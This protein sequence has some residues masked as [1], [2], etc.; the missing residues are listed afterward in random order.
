MIFFHYYQYHHHY[1]YINSHDH[2]C[3]FYLNRTVT[4]DLFQEICSA[5]G[6]CSFETR[7]TFTLMFNGALSS[8]VINV[9]VIF[10]MIFYFYTE[11]IGY[12]IPV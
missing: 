12:K 5:R 6:K 11:Q 10:D 8:F 1:N 4:E 7:L 3:L 9:P 2:H